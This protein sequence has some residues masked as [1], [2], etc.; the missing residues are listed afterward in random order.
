MCRISISPGFLNKSPLSQWVTN[1][2]THSLVHNLLVKIQLLLNLYHSPLPFFSLHSILNPQLKLY[3]SSSLPKN[4]WTYRSFISEYIVSCLSLL[5]CIVNVGGQG[6]VQVH[7]LMSLSDLQCF[8]N[9]VVSILWF[10]RK[11]SLEDCGTKLQLWPPP[12]PWR[13]WWVVKWG[14]V[15]QCFCIQNLVFPWV[16]WFINRLVWGI[17]RS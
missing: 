11:E 15:H 5:S 16:N 8:N 1:L 2:L 6:E 14:R 7:F 9:R 3:S 10:K 13:E 12:P 17:L 4:L